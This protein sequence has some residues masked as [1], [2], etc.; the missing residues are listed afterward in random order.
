MDGDSLCRGAYYFIDDVCVSTDSSF[1]AN[2]TGV[3]VISNEEP[4][5]FY[6]NPLS[7]VLILENIKT[8]TDYRIISALGQ[9]VSEGR[10]NTGTDQI[11]VSMISGGVYFLE[12]NN[13]I[14]KLLIYH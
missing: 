11:D 8:A 6:P 3:E 13:S 1:A 9:V 7:S 5:L 12:F 14:Y 2:F 4:F 10:V